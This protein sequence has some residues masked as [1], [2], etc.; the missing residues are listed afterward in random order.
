[1][2][3][4]LITEFRKLKGSLVTVLCLVAPSLVAVLVGLIALQRPNMHWEF[5]LT[6]ATGLWSFFVLP[7][8][9]T[10]L[11][12]LLAQ[13]EHAP[14]AW[15]HLLALPIRRWKLFAAKAVVIMTLVA[16]M[17]LLLAAELRL[18]GELLAM[19]APTFAPRGAYDWSLAARILGSMWLASFFMGMIQLWV[20]LRFRSFV[21]PLTIGLAGTFISVAAFN[22]K[23]AMFVPWAMPV[24]IV[25]AQGVNAAPALLM[26]SIGGLATLLLMLAHLSRR[27]A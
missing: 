27:E 14:R 16:I 10:A 8:S 20:A 12:V 22:A 26:G 5:V 25:G 19:L 21:A 23:E 13:I 3:V 9:V 24:S 2:L 18:V 11:S 6:G 4:V 7:M 1:M 17:S 15:D